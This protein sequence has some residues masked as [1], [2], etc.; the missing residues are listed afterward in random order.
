MTLTKTTTVEMLMTA[1]TTGLVM[2]VAQ[3]VMMMMMM[4]M[5]R[6]MT[7]AR[8]TMTSR[9]EDD[10]DDEGAEGDHGDCHVGY[11]ANKIAAE[12]GEQ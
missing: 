8:I 1:M 10:S 11:M 7:E 9:V 2:I 4:T 3:T 5:Q 12:C 6:A